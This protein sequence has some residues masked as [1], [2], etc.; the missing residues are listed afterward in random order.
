MKKVLTLIVLV[1]VAATCFAGPR[2]HRGGGPRHHGGHHHHHHRG[3]DGV[4]LAAGIVNIVANGLNILNQ[5]RTVYVQQPVVQQSVVVT[6]PPVVTPTVV[7]PQQVVVPTTTPTVI[8]QK[9]A[10]P[11]LLYRLPDGTEVY[12]YR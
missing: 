7:V 11:V 6:P 2:G 1:L 9:P 4:W 3:S 5:P 10:G 8:Y 12:G